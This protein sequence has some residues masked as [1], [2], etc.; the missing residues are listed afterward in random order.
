MPASGCGLN[1]YFHRNAITTGVRTAGAKKI[2][3]ST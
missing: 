1:M 3:R 2:V